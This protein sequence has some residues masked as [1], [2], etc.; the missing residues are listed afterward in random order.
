MAV[1]DR[2]PSPPRSVRLQRQR[3]RSTAG[4][5]AQSSSGTPRAEESLLSTPS[6]A[7]ACTSFQLAPRRKPGRGR[8]KR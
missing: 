8:H 4:S 7:P 3:P 5:L 6:P 2:Y 1:E